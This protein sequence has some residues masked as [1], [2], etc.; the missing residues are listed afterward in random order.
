[1]F[2]IVE[3]RRWFFLITG[4][5]IALSIT[6]LIIS[7]IQLGLPV[8]ISTDPTSTGAT[9]TAWLTVLAVAVIVPAFVLWS[10]RSMPKV[11]RYSICSIAVL[12]HN[13]L[14][15]CGFYALMGVIAGWRMDTFFLIAVLTIIGLTAQGV[16]T[17]FDRIRENAPK[18]LGEPY[19]TVANRA[20]LETVSPLLATRLCAAF[21]M[22]ALVITGGATVQPLF[23]TV[24]V[25][26]A[27]EVYT[28][29]F[30]TAPLLAAWEKAAAK[31]TAARAAA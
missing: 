30:I 2:N 15:T 16:I 6:A 24:L 28:A 17:V 25:G 23:A 26:M 31:R 27:S 5:L 22:V 1:M 14:I 7:T 3:K 12:L 4:V 18:R 8:W 13:L 11:L 9:K 20:T 10:F 19:D 29:V 21:V